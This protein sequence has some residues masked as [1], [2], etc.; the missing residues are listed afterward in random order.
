MRREGAALAWRAAIAALV[1]VALVGVSLRLRGEINVWL[2]TGAAGLAGVLV[3]LW[4][5][6]GRLR[7]RLRPSPGSTAIG[8]VAGVAMVGLTVLLYPVALALVAGIRGE[9]RELYAALQDPPGPLV[10][11]PILILVVTAEELVY[12][13]VVVTALGERLRAPATGALAV[14]IYLLPQLLG[15]SWVLTGVAFAC[16]VVWTALRFLTGGIWSPWLCHV[17]WDVAVFVVF[18]LEPPAGR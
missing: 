3:A 15:G 1:M 10:A 13:D 2:S 4:A 6:R 14:G 9:V 11:T 17:L 8:V 18:P 16:G 7:Y 12:R 5:G